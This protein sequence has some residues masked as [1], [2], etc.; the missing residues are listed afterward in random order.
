M[1]TVRRLATTG[2]HGLGVAVATFL[3]TIPG[4]VRTGNTKR[5]YARPLQLAV[6]QFGED[7]ALGAID[8]DEFAAWFTRSYGNLAP[9]TWNTTLSIVRSAFSYWR[10]QGWAAP[11]PSVRLRR[12]KP[13]PDRDRVLPASLVD[14]L[15]TSDR[16]PLRERLLWRML[17]ETAARSAEVLRLDVPDLDRPNRRTRVTRKG[18]AQDVIIWQTETARLLP[19]Y[20]GDRAD[21]PLF[22]TGRRAR[23]ELP[24][25]DIH[26]A[27]GRARLSYRQAE[28]IF[29]EASGGATLHQWRHTAITG[30]AEDGLSTPMMMAR[31]G[32]TSVRSLARYAWPSAQALQRLQEER[33]PARRR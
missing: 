31:S 24:P 15:L 2:D 19:R 16:Y 8:P 14:Q 28:A 5:A 12:R 26:R 3:D 32:H 1:G 29:K 11:D 13:P 27:S 17:H 10:E 23:V 30:D 4:D 18:G 7:A 21:G 20:L 6:T 33:D 25:G 22:L 9:S